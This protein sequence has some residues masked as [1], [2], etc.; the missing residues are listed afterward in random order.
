MSIDSARD[1]SCSSGQTPVA[2]TSRITKS[3]KRIGSPPPLV[4]EV[5]D[6][7]GHLDKQRDWHRLSVSHRENRVPPHAVGD[8]FHL[9]ARSRHPTASATEQ[10]RGILV[11][12]RLQLSDSG[13]VQRRP[14]WS[15]PRFRDQRV[16]QT[17]GGS[18]PRQRSSSKRQAVAKPSDRSIR[19]P[20]RTR[21][22][23]CPVP[24]SAFSPQRPCLRL[25]RLGTER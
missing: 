19:P 21:T 3:W 8:R 7:A 10:P 4:F 6:A 24:A 2:A 18:R 5:L 1:A 16:V 9:P 22:A 23:H 12:A 17:G 15:A 11:I 14:D 20:A 25:A 13:R